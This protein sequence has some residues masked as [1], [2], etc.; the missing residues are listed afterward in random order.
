MIGSYVTESNLQG[1]PGVGG[2]FRGW[3]T[4]CT[5]LART[6]QTP[7]AEWAAF[8]MSTL[9]YLGS[10]SV[11]SSKVLALIRP[12]SPGLPVDVFAFVYTEK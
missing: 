7:G 11:R 2:G 6:G 5:E 10:L 1:L 4:I 8:S 12:S 9:V 3:D